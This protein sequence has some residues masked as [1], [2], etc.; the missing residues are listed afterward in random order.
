MKDILFYKRLLI[1]LLFVLFID[2]K[3]NW[4][5]KKKFNLLRKVIILSP[6]SPPRPQR[7]TKRSGVDRVK[8]SAFLFSTYTF[9]ASPQGPRDL[10]F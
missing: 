10:S 5:W 6:P 4:K 9:C 7:H 1:T 2:L 3:F 8:S